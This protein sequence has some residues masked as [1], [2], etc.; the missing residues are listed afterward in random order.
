LEQSLTDHQLGERFQLTE[1]EDLMMDV[2]SESMEAVAD[3]RKVSFWRLHKF[4][5]LRTIDIAKDRVLAAISDRR[6][7]NTKEWDR[8]KTM[9]PDEWSDWLGTVAGRT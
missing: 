1:D 8:L 3:L 2:L 6:H 4:W 5:T 7:G 9:T